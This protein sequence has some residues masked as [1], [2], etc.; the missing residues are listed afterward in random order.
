MN[1]R[2]LLGG[3][4]AAVALGIGAYFIVG[5]RGGDDAKPADPGSTASVD[6]P[7][8]DVPGAPVR[9]RVPRRVA[10]DDGATS[11]GDY[12]ETYEDGSRRRDHRPGNPEPSMRPVLPH[13]SKSPVTAQVTSIAMQTLRP[14]VMACLKEL[15]DSAFTE[16]A[17]VVVRA[18]VSI[19]EEGNLTAS[20][21]GPKSKGI[22]EAA[23]EPALECIRNAA[24]SFNAQVDHPAV[25]EAVL[26]LQVRPGRRAR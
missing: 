8:R 2:V 15:P 4:V 13:R 19:D 20:D 17:R 11:N 12:V 7:E 5:D 23:V 21:L 25:A 6:T 9:A 3:A 22:D 16:E 24:S 14:L 18:A 26:S 10:G 1:Q